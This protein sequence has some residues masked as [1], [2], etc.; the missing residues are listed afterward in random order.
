[1]EVGKVRDSD[2]EWVIPDSNN[3]E[4]EINHIEIPHERTRHRHGALTE[5]EQSILRSE[6]GE[7]MW[8][9]RISRPGAIYDDS[10]AAQTFYGDKMIGD[11]DGN[12]AIS[13]IAE[14]GDLREDSKNHFWE[15]S[16]F[17]KNLTGRKS[18]FGKLQL[19]KKTR[20]QTHRKRI[21]RH[22]ICYF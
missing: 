13:E 15:Y 16:W 10:V 8:I 22:R 18:D 3:Y 14:K 17:P 19:L 12:A 5:E 1:M 2:S 9:A 20:S 6:L 11:L 4:G 7:L 21:L